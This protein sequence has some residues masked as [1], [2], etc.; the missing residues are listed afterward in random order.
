MSADNTDFF[1]F[2]F[3][4]S[5]KIDLLCQPLLNILHTGYKFQQMNFEIF[6]P[7]TTI[8]HFMHIV[9]LGDNLHEV[10]NPIFWEK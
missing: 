1:L 2:L 5:R 7:E 6:F 9:S 3:L 8:W 10:S 4:F